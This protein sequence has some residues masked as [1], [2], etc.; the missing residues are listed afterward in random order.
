VNGP[1]G[2]FSPAI[3]DCNR[4]ISAP[5]AVKFKQISLDTLKKD[6][7]AQLVANLA[8]KLEARKEAIRAQP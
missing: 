5:R 7:C 4:Y 1:T 3:G 8:E 6:V 2:L